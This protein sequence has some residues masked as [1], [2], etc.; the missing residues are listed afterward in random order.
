LERI[1]AGRL[2]KQIADD[3]GISIKTVE[4]HRANIMEKLNANTVADL[5]KISAGTK[6]TQGL[7]AQA[8]SKLKRPHPSGVLHFQR[9]FRHTMTA[10]LIDGN[11]LSK[12]LRAQVAAARAQALKAKGMTPGLGRGAGRRQPRQPGLCAQQ[13][14]GL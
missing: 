12:Q 4:A 3:L 2:N 1:V 14:Q 5:L 6:R 9:L 7:I 10:Q 11:A 8:P 13:S